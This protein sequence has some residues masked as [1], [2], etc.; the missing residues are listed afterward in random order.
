MCFPIMGATS[1]CLGELKTQNTTVSQQQQ[2]LEYLDTVQISL[3]FHKGLSWPMFSS[4]VT[5]MT[6]FSLAVQGGAACHGFRAS[7]TAQSHTV[8]CT[9][10]PP[11]SH[12]LQETSLRWLGCWVATVQHT[13]TASHSAAQGAL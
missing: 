12:V 13:A 3:L 5:A 4:A 6:V 11:L 8:H 10:Q 2:K 7:L 9:V 1:L